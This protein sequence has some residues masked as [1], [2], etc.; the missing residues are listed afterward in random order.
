MFEPL[1]AGPIPF[2]AMGAAAMRLHHIWTSITLA[3]LCA[4]A[5]LQIAAAATYQMTIKSTPEAGGKR[6][7][8]PAGP[9]VEGMRVFIWDCGPQLA[10]NS[11][12]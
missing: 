7:S 1:S 3:A 9:F 6:V 4:P 11:C 8:T 10:Q 5:P 2:G 12:L